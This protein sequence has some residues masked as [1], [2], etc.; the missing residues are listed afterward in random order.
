MPFDEL[1]FPAAF[2]LSSNHYIVLTDGK[3]ILL[4]VDDKEYPLGGGITYFCGGGLSMA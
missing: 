4:S 2:Q 3:G 1:S